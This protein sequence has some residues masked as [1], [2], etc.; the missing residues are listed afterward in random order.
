ME[1]SVYSDGQQQYG[2]KSLTT[3]FANELYA[4]A[5]TTLFNGTGNVFKHEGNAIDR[6]TFS[7][8][9]VLYAFDL[10]PDQG[11]VDHFNLTKQ[12][13]VRLVLKFREAL[14]ENVT[15]IAY[16]EFQN[17]IEIDRN[18]NVIYDFAV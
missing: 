2:I 14:N 11:K 15:A 18:R 3:D 10:T 13:S 12:G 7:K 4:R 17:V 5:Y 9:Y 1:I 16:A 6:T 8:G